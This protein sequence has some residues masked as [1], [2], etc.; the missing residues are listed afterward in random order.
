MGMSESKI[1]EVRAAGERD[2]LQLS[3]E[4][5]AGLSAHNGHK[6]DPCYN[7]NWNK[8]NKTG[9]LR[10]RHLVMSALDF[11]YG[12]CCGSMRTRK[13]MKQDLVDYVLYRGDADLNAW[14]DERRTLPTETE[15]DLER[16][17]R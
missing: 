8:A 5:L 6:P 9:T 10:A 15:S 1:N 4:A 13:A 12:I 7:E 17:R 16:A 14:V 11:R 3:R 2:G